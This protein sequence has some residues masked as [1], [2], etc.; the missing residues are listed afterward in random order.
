M[1]P[2]TADPQVTA[3]TDDHGALSPRAYQA[4][5][6]TAARARLTCDWREKERSSTLGLLCHRLGR[7]FII[8]KKRTRCCRILFGYSSV[9]RRSKRRVN[10]RIAEKEPRT[11]RRDELAD[12]TG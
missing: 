4:H 1:S 12:Y 8:V 10:L 2:L 11:Q 5:V 6:S 3:T 7:R 9:R